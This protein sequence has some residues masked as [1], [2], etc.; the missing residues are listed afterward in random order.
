MKGLTSQHLSVLSIEFES[1]KWPELDSEREV[2][3][4]VWPYMLKSS[5]FDLK[6]IALMQLS[7][8]A[9]NKYSQFSEKATAVWHDPRSNDLAATFYLLSHNLQVPSSEAEQI[10]SCLKSIEFTIDWWPRNCLTL[11]NVCRSQRNTSPLYDLA[12]WAP[13]E[14][15]SFSS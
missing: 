1:R 2:I 3:V 11:W 8:P 12:S 7:I 4:S 13:Q 9:T 5:E 10:W 14:T 6:F 15:R